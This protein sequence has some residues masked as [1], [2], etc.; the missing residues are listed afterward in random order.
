[1]TGLFATD[2]DIFFAH[3]GSNVG[4]ANWGDFGF[5][6][7]IFGPVEEALVGHDSDSDVV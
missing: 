3:S 6:M 4:V 7:T 5:D 2:G 1:M